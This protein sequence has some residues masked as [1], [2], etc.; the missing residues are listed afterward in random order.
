VTGSLES[1][2]ETGHGGA[3]Y[4]SVAATEPVAEGMRDED[5]TRPGA[6]V[7][8]GGDDALAA[9]VW[10]ILHGDPAWVD[11]HGREDTD[12]VPD[13]QLLAFVEVAQV[14]NCGRLRASHI[15][16]NENR[17]NRPRI[18]NSLPTSISL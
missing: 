1:S 5:I 16:F 3:G 8:G 11:E 17:V 7:V 12:I 9:R 2:A 15:V 4:G 6:E 14:A 18:P 10:V 13:R